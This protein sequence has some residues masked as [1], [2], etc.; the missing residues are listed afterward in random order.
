[1]KFNQTALANSLAL[2]MA[3]FY[4]VFYLA[5]LLT[6]DFF[7]FLFNAQFLGADVASLLPKEIPPLTFVGTLLVLAITGWLFGYVWAWLYN[8]LSRMVD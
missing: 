8:R 3:A 4:I 6:Q 7:E 5:S 1:M 2:L